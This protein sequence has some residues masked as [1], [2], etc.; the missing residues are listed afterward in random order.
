VAE[1][2]LRNEIIEWLDNLAD[3]EWDRAVLIVDRLP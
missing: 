3:H 1:V 2:E